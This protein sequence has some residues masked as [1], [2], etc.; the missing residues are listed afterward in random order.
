MPP[1]SE[2]ATLGREGGEGGASSYLGAVLSGRKTGS[3]NSGHMCEE[4][5]QAEMC[6]VGRGGEAPL[7]AS[8]WVPTAQ[9]HLP[10]FTPRS[11][12]HIS[13]Q[14]VSGWA[15]LCREQLLILLTCLFCWSKPR[16]KALR[17]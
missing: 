8:H 3:N 1:S 7:S 6:C 10:S 4:K 17:R 14:P 11:P 12:P 13:K 9:R 2:R 5:L 15:A 16:T